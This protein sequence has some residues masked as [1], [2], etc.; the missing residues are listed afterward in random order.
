MEKNDPIKECPHCKSDEGYFIKMQVTGSVKCH[1]GFD[2]TE[3][4]N[5]D[6]YGQLI[7]KG[8]NVA[9]CSNCQKKLFKI[10]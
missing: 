10:L 4:D 1:V 8:G 2:G 5:S 3:R 6:M 7:H 9:Y